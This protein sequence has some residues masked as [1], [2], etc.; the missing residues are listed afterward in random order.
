[1]IVRL[2]SWKLE[3]ACSIRQPPMDSST[4]FRSPKKCVHLFYF[5]LVKIKR[6]HSFRTFS[7]TNCF[8]FYFHLSLPLSLQP[9][10]SPLTSVR[11]S[12]L[13]HHRNGLR[14]TRLLCPISAHKSA[15]TTQRRSHTDLYSTR[16]LAK[17]ST[18]N[19]S[20]LPW[21]LM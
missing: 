20:P 2:Y 16:H 21:I 1:M 5:M 12:A 19:D 11:L 13:T 18:A 14:I 10:A 17:P 15:A 7:Y 8:H 3:Y 4:L 6:T 9:P